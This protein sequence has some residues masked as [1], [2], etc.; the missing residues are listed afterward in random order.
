MAKVRFVS[1]KIFVK[2]QRGAR[3]IM[4]RAATENMVHTAVK[5]ATLEAR[6]KGTLKMG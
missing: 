4:L 5:H 6:G 3:S 1:E 2:D